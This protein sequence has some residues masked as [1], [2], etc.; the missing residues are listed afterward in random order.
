[1]GQLAA[2]VVNTTPR[3]RGSKRFQAADFYR[4]SWKKTGIASMLSPK[5]QA[6]INRKKAKRE[7]ANG[8][9]RR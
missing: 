7:K 9:K 3:P 1:M 8:H 4:E 2:T 6:Y 5:Q